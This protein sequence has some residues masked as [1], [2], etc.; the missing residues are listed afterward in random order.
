[1]GK[2]RKLFCEYGPIC[3]KISLYKEA[4]RKDWRDFKAKKKFAKKIEKKIL[5]IFGKVILKYY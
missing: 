3:Y 1:M 4:L 2:K 5:N